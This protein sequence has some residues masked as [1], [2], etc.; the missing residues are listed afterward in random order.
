MNRDRYSGVEMSYE[1]Y[2]ACI[3]AC[4]ACA[5][6][7]TCCASASLQEDHGKSMARFIALDAECAQSRAFTESALARSSG[8]AAA[9]CLMCASTCD[10]CA[11]ECG[12]YAMDRCRH[13][14][15]ECRRCAGKCRN[16]AQLG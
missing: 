1:Q 14:A 6:A 15:T 4:N 3:D 8:F 13:W 12:K 16:V 11:D 10:A 5:A 2:R 7:C 9:I